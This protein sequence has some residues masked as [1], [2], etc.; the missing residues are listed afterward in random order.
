LTSAVAATGGV[1]LLDADELDGALHAGL[2]TTDDYALAW[3]EAHRLLAAIRERRFPLP[4]LA[5]AHRRLLPP[6]L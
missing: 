6:R 4:A 3:R 5:A 1:E 2:I